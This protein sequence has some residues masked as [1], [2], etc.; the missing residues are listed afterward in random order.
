MASRT[1]PAPPK[2]SGFPS[3]TLPSASRGFW[4]PSRTLPMPPGALWI[5]FRTLRCLPNR[6]GSDPEPSGKHPERS[7]CFPECSGCFPESAA[8]FHHRPHRPIFPDGTPAAFSLPD[9]FRRIIWIHPPGPRFSA[10]PDLTEWVRTLP[11]DSRP[12]FAE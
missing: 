11:C 5:A 3:R 4:I 2:P 12:G 6:S 10:W 7:R 8:N 1:L 9:L